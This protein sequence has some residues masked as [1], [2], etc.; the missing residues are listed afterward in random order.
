MPPAIQLAKLQG[1]RRAEHPTPSTLAHV[2]MTLLHCGSSFAHRV[3]PSCSASCLSRPSRLIIVGTSHHHHSRWQ[4]S[5]AH[6]K[7][8]AW[9]STLSPCISFSTPSS[10]DRESEPEKQE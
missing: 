10:F 3:R 5:E 4:L 6:H 9:G 8:K 7:K 2:K 1:A